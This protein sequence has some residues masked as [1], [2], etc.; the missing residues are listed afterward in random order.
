MNR[1]C[2]SVVPGPR[3]R[4]GTRWHNVG[5]PRDVVIVGCGGMGR[6]TVDLI[7]RINTAKPANRWNILGFVDDNP[8]DINLKRVDA[9]G[10]SLVGTSKIAIATLDSPYFVLGIGNGI[11]RRGLAGVF[12]KAGWEPATL[13]DPS[14]FVGRGVEI[15]AGSILAAGA[16][17]ATNA[18]LGRHVHVNVNSAV[19]EDTVVGDY[20]TCNALV[21]ISGGCVIGEGANLGSGS[22][23]I[24]GVRVGRDAIVGA[25]ACVVRDVRAGATV[26]GVP[27]T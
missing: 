27:A 14:A 3:S 6:E 20:A 8:S 26:K 10:L 12:E 7:D 18:R 25:G 17:V 22:T 4:R 13:V 11:T 2:P 23:V 5:M 1:A 15:G 19:G 24:P 21:T 16:F 9:L